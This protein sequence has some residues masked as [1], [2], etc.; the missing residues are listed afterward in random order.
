[1]IASKPLIS[2]RKL[3]RPVRGKSMT[4]GVGFVCSDGIVLCSDT[5]ITWAGSHKAYECKI[6]THYGTDCNVMFTYG[7][8]PEVMKAFFG[9]FEASMVLLK[10]PHTTPLIC[11]VIETVLELMGSD[12]VGENGPEH[13]MLC[14]V[15]GVDERLELFKTTGKT[16]RKVDWCDVVGC[17]DS[18]LIRYWMKWIKPG[19]YSAEYGLKVGAFLVRQAIAHVDDCGGDIDVRILRPDGM[20]EDR[21]ASV[22]TVT[23]RLGIIEYQAALVASSFLNADESDERFEEQLS[24]LVSMLKSDRH[25]LSFG[26]KWKPRKRV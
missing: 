19:E 5:Q 21:T 1:M 6:F 14:S 11:E 13:Y 4:I 25:S 20:P 18:S 22:P 7:G 9:K 3:R 17:G 12:I 8:Y 16:L 23:Q 24:Y 15:F 2:V 26:R 10:K